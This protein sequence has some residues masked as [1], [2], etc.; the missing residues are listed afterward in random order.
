MIV[1]FR[2][3]DSERKKLE[4]K[5]QE[6]N[7]TTSDYIRSIIFDANENFKD[8]IDFYK[9]IHFSLEELTKRNLILNQML[10]QLMIKNMGEEKADQ[11]CEQISNCVDEYINTKS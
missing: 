11:I 1:S 6:A 2:V 4:V 3:S 10:Y 8:K 9:N 5:A 7:R